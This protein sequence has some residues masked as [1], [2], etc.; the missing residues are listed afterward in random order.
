M[1]FF[2]SNYFKVRKRVSVSTKNTSIETCILFTGQKAGK[3]NK[4]GEF[5][6]T[7][8]AFQNQK[9]FPAKEQTLLETFRMRKEAVSRFEKM[10]VITGDMCIFHYKN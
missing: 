6:T 8:R 3:T 4:I 9:V 1:P 10:Q 5:L 2:Y 7:N